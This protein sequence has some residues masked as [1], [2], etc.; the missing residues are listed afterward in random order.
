MLLWL[1]EGVVYS[2]FTI[3]LWVDS[4]SVS[5]CGYWISGIL[6]LTWEKFD[7]WKGGGGGGGMGGDIL[8]G[9]W[10]GRDLEMVATV[11]SGAGG[12]CIHSRSIY[13]WSGLGWKCKKN[14]KVTVNLW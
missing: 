14:L 9:G 5:S 4:F 6:W 13:S 1:T 11:L 8:S 2:G 12:P 3:S 7:K 10:G